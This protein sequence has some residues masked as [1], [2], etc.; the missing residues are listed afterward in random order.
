[1]IPLRA[2]DGI[3]VAFI[4][5]R[6]P[7]AGDDHG[8]KYLNSPDTALFTKGHV[9][10]GLAE[11]RRSLTSGAQPVLVE[12]PLDAIAVSIAV[13]GHYTGITPYGT[14]LTGEHVAALA[15]TVSLPDR[16]LLIAFDGDDGGRKAAA[17]AYAHLVPVT[18]GVTAA[19]LPD[20]TDPASILAS[21]GRQALAG[22]LTTGTRP[23]AAL[24]VDA[25]IENWHA[26]VSSSS[27]SCKWA[28]S[29]PP[30]R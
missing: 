22:T 19:V 20:G 10:A 18:G 15:R 12:G 23:L 27:P 30:P 28:R 9:L 3:V 13:P 4:G 7:D 5:R 14:A 21:H 26:A 6:H 25:A 1:M 16:G 8:P 24:P 17:R 29:A 11:G 2:E